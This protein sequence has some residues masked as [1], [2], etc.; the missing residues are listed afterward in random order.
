VWNRDR[1]R[2]TEVRD[3]GGLVVEPLAGGRRVDLAPDYVGSSVELGYATT[4]YGVQGQTVDRAH[5]VQP[6]GGSVESLYVDLTRARER[7]IVHVATTPEPEVADGQVHDVTPRPAAAVL[8]EAIERESADRAAVAVADIEAE[9]H[10]SAL[11]LVERWSEQV[12]RANT[13]RLAEGLALLAATGEIHDDIPAAVAADESRAQL[14]WLLRRVEL[15]GHDPDVALRDAATRGSFTGARSVAQVLHGRISAAYRDRL[16]PAPAA[17]AD[18]VP[19]VGGDRQR[20]LTDLAS[21]VDDRRR[22]S[23]RRSRSRRRRGPSTC[24]ARVPADPLARLEWED[25]AGR[26]ALHREVAG[27]RRRAA[28]D[29]SVPVAGPG[30]AGRDLARRLGRARPARAVPRRSGDDRR[31]AAGA[32]PRRRAG[33]A[34]GAGVRRR[35]VARF[36]RR[37]G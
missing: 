15:A 34:P 31:A 17:T 19:T 22:R 3:D 9:T 28:A 36:V 6:A 8:A 26:V 35:G 13:S 4:E 7:T 24:S 33:R 37:V 21:L 20:S 10:S 18:R 25:R 29:R 16:T 5:V 23:A 2:V 30:G 27:P 12:A 32:G 14:S 1:W 11:T